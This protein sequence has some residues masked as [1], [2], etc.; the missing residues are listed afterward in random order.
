[1]YV[2]L[3]Y[4]VRMFAHMAFDHRAIHEFPIRGVVGFEILFDRCHALL[5]HED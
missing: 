3:G 4:A 5:V 1:M 2:A